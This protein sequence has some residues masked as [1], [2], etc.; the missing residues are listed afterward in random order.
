MY[1]PS[2]TPAFFTWR[3]G[4]FFVRQLEGREGCDT[5]LFLLYVKKKKKKKLDVKFM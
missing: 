3:L 2:S 4:G 5:T 1:P